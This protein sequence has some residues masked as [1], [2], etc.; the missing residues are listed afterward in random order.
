[1]DLAAGKREARQA[2]DSV[3]LERT[4]RVGLV[5]YGVVHLLIAWLALQLAFGQQS[6]PAGQQGALHELATQPFG[7]ALLWIVAIGFFALAIWQ[8]TEAIWGH[9]REDGA[10]RVLKR[11]GSAGKAV[12][13]AVIG[14]SALKIAI[15]AGAHSQ[16]QQTTARIM[17]WP[18]G[19]LLVAAAGLV[20]VVVAVVQAKRGITTSFTKD[21]D[22][23]ATSGTSGETVLRLGQVGYIAK[24]VALGVLGGLFVWAAWTYDAKKAGG[25]DA[26]LSTLLKAGVG[27]WLLVVVALGIACFGL[28]A[29]AWARYADTTT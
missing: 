4:V 23:G 15:G 20:V 3:W 26:A 9:S 22:A 21:L 16:S 7:T 24:G 18:F 13:Y 10:K 27:P 29:F 12:V 14:Y 11:V 8:V 6:A 17:S 1:M 2:A 5:A 28:Y 25:L 19:R